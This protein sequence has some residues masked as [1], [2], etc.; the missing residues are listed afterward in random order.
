M[1]RIAIAL[2]ALAVLG[3]CTA[4]TGNSSTSSALALA[5]KAAVESQVYY[6][7]RGIS[8][9]PLRADQLDDSGCAVPVR[10][11]FDADFAV[12]HYAPDGEPLLDEDHIV[13]MWQIAEHVTP[14]DGELDEGGADLPVAVPEPNYPTP[15]LDGRLDLNPVSDIARRLMKTGINAPYARIDWLRQ[16]FE[17]MLRLPPGA[18]PGCS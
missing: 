6:I 14:A 3:A 7:D 16:Y 11:T 4:D 1:A 5:D 9:A 2:T 13:A 12:A 18:H 15:A 8:D 17:D 10:I